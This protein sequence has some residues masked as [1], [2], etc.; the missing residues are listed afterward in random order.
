[1]YDEIPLI[2][3]DLTLCVWVLEVCGLFKTVHSCYE[4]GFC[5]TQRQRIALYVASPP[6]EG[7]FQCRGRFRLGRMDP[8]EEGRR[9]RRVWPNRSTWIP[10]HALQ[11]GSTINS[12][13]TEAQYATEVLGLEFWIHFFSPGRRSSCKVPLLFCRKVSMIF[14]VKK[15]GFEN[16]SLEL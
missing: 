9:P 10:H 6:Y 15:M 5:Y 13:H 14:L 11:W 4:I 7:L 12:G 1:M 2:T 3:Q 8:L 16:W